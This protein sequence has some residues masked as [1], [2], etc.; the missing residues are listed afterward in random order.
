MATGPI[1]N[2]CS[3]GATKQPDHFTAQQAAAGARRSA[4]A[5]GRPALALAVTRRRD[6][7]SLFPGN[8]DPRRRRG[9]EATQ[10]M[11]YQQPAPLHGAQTR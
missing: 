7:P 1:T 8:I 6:N 9:P 3:A 4:T 5:A 10:H 2:H 11:Y